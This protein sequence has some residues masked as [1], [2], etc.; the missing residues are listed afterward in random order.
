MNY[1]LAYYKYYRL[2]KCDPLFC[3]I[4]GKIAVNLHHINYGAG[5]KDDNVSNLIPLCYGCHDGHHTQNKPT[6][7]EIKDAKATI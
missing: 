5:I 1:K 3:A 2:A 7:K 4:C 6:T